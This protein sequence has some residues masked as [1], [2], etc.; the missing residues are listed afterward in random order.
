MISILSIV[1]QI[2]GMK[3]ILGWRK[4][5]YLARSSSLLIAAALIAGMVGCADTPG[6]S[7][8]YSLAIA[9]TAGGN[10]TTLGEW[11][12]CY[13]ANYTVELV[14]E[15]DD[16]HHFVN[17]AGDV[18]TIGNVTAA[19]TN[20]TM[21]GNYSI[22]AN[23]ELDEGWYSLTIFSS[24]GGSVAEPGEGYSA[25]AANTTAE[26]VAE[27]DDYRQFDYRFKGWTGDVDTIANANAAATN[28]RMDDSYSIT[29]NFEWFD[30]IQVAAG[31]WHT[32]GLKNDGTVVAVGYCG[33]DLCNVGSWTDIIQ[34]SAGHFHTVGLKAEG[35][36]LAAGWNDYGQ[37]NVGSWT[38]ITQIAAGFGHTVGL[39]V[40]GTVVAV[41]NNTYGQCDVS[42]WTNIIQVAA[43]FGHTVGLKSDGTVVAVGRDD[44]GQCNV[45]GWSYISQIATGWDQTFGIKSG[46][47]AV[48]VGY[49]DDG[50]CDIGRWTDIKQVAAGYF[51]TVGVKSDGTVVA[52]GWDMYDLCCDVGSWTDT[53]QVAAGLR[54]TVGLGADGTAVAAGWGGYGECNVG[55]W[56]P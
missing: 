6:H 20:I 32:V 48:A 38:G 21:C 8:C 23:F 34:V 36:V 56:E 1:R 31:C 44:S 5:N 12:W 37:C 47:T 50:Q 52:V 43:G 46:G 51:H 33:Y 13:A 45:D 42:G 40:D 10:A 55:G 19:A 25:Y 54:H 30:I 16:H 27:P 7:D 3:I 26:L 11:T 29:A 24:Y 53:I 49:S 18:D 14:A 41:G 9:S 28:I 2:R 35:T 15:P 4:S 22:I 39:K 17:W